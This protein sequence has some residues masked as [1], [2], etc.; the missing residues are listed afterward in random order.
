MNIHLKK[1][2]ACDIVEEGIVDKL[3]NIRYYSEVLDF[4]DFHKKY[5]DGSL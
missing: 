2:V 3:R 1:N 5:L 4:V